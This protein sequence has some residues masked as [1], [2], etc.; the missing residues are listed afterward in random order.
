MEQKASVPYW[1]VREE[2]TSRPHVAVR[3]RAVQTGPREVTQGTSR[4]HVAVLEWATKAGSREATLGTS[5]PHVAVRGRAAQ[6]A[7][8]PHVAVR[9][10]AA[11]AGPREAVKRTNRWGREARLW[12]TQG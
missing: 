3:G 4:P 1:A 12:G 7:S 10:R 11:Q 8:R 5:R 6:T 9:G 2:G